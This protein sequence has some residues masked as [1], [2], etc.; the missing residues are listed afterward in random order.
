[1]FLKR[2]LLTPP[3]HKGAPII[4]DIAIL[5]RVIDEDGIGRVKKIVIIEV[6]AFHGTLG[7]V[8]GSLSRRRPPRWSSIGGWTWIRWWTIRRRDFR[9]KG[10]GFPG[11]QVWRHLWSPTLAWPSGQKLIWCQFNLRRNST[12]ILSWYFAR[13]ISIVPLQPIR[14]SIDPNANCRVYTFSVI[15]IPLHHHS[16]TVTPS[17]E[18]VGNGGVKYYRIWKLQ[19]SITNTESRIKLPD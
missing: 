4:V 18:V 1:M 5:K 10:V 6:C 3:W 7:A 17:F 12:I 14:G 2:F 15:V 19:P 9:R 8:D 13:R 11:F 16:P